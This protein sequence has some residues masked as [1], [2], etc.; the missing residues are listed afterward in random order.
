MRKLLS[1]GLIALSVGATCLTFSQPAQAQNAWGNGGGC[2]SQGN[3]GN[4]NGNG[5]GRGHGR[6]HHKH[7]HNRGY[8]NQG[9]NSGFNPGY[10][11]GY[12][13]A[14]N[15]GINPGYNN[16]YGQL[17][18][19]G[20][21]PGVITTGYNQPYYNGNNQGFL[22]G[23]NQ[24]FFNGNSR[25]LFGNGFN[26]NRVDGIQ[27]RLGSLITGGMANGNL[28]QK[29][30]DRLLARQAKI[31]QLQAQFTS[32]GRLNY[33]E[34]NRLSSEIGRLRSQLQRELNDRN[35]Y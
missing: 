11:G 1:V 14:Y 21:N 4:G 10:N 8:G 12:N 25:G 28:T 26:N 9:F 3:N 6:G 18:N 15:N 23:N 30:A 16:V 31:D 35:V 19:N 34:R 22:N 13:S 29:E 7:H 24:G 2:S 33:N 5:W 17:F 27:S 32:D 20:V